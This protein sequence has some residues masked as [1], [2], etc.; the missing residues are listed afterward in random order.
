MS[1]YDC[2]PFSAIGVS[3]C[4]LQYS[5]GCGRSV[6]DILSALRDHRRN[7]KNG[8][9]PDILVLI[10]ACWSFSGSDCEGWIKRTIN[11]VYLSSIIFRPDRGKER[12]P[13]LEEGSSERKDTLPPLRQ[14]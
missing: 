8:P 11:L 5:A 2:A 12:L 3:E 6:S 10:D 13:V 4:A 1:S 14:I 7:L 9:S